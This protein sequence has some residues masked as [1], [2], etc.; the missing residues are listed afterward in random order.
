[1]D[2][3]TRRYVITAYSEWEALDVEAMCATDEQAIDKARRYGA[4]K[5]ID[6]NF[7]SVIFAHVV[8]EDETGTREVGTWEFQVRNVKRPGLLWHSGPWPC[9][10]SAEDRSAI[11]SWAAGIAKAD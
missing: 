2:A 11:R 3:S 7:P 6:K 8:C 5:Y 9:R 1:M 4:L 10:P